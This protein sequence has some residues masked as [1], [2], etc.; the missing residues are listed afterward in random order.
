MEGSSQRRA[1]ENAD[2]DLV[3]ARAKAPFSEV[4]G[5]LNRMQVV[6]DAMEHVSEMASEEEVMEDVSLSSNIFSRSSISSR[7]IS[8]MPS[9]ED[10]V[11][12]M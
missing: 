1:R 10:M 7:S 8:E 6:R 3:F 2:V 12:L 11:F 5:E 9:R 4:V